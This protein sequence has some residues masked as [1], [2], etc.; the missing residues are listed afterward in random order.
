MLFSLNAAAATFDFR[1]VADQIGGPFPT[2]AGSTAGG[3]GSWTG[4]VG[5]GVGLVDG[6]I[7]VVGSATNSAG[8]NPDAYFDENSAGLGVCS[9]FDGIECD[10]S[11]DDN[12]GALGGSGNVGDGSFET[13]I[14]TFNTLVSLDQVVFAGEGHG[15]FTGDVL[16]NGSTETPVGNILALGLIGTVF[17]FQYIPQLSGVVNEFYVESVT[18]SAVPLP[19]ALPLFL[20]MLAGMGFMRWRWRRNEAV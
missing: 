2:T 5:A 10:P 4:I 17:S 8:G 16:V 12:I 6:G 20:T 13:L 1:N 14:L 15:N 9:G 7:S 18:V 19:G 3:E 11:N